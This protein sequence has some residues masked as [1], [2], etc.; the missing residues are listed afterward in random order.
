MIDPLE[1]LAK[2]DERW[3]KILKLQEERDALPYPLTV[4]TARYQ[5]TY[6]GAFWLAF[7]EAP[8]SDYL[9]GAHGDDLR[10]AAFFDIYEQFKPIGRGNSAQEA[11]DDLQAKLEAEPEK[12]W[13]R[14]LWNGQLG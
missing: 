12:A 10:C 8:G 3:A 14:F 13:P 11:I 1:E 2:T 7:N 6:E 5:G 4:S 9:H